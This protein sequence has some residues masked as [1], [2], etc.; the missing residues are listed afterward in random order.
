MR[1]EASDAAR[2]AIRRVAASGRED[3]VLVL[4]TGCCDSTAPYLYDHYYP[5]RDAVQVGDVQGV[6]VF[7]HRWLADLYAGSHG[8]QVDCRQDVVSD[9]FSLESELGCRLTLRVEIPREGRA[10]AG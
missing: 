1:V 3:L 9:S 7:A 10:A 5:G 8:L 2:D 4:G 6:P